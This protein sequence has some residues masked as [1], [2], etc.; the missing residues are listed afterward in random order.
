[1]VYADE[2]RSLEPN[3]LLRLPDNVFELEGAWNAKI[4]IVPTKLHPFSSKKANVALPS[5]VSKNAVNANALD[6]KNKS[7]PHVATA[8]RM[9]TWR[10]EVRKRVGKVANSIANQSQQLGSGTLPWQLVNKH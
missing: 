8:L 4:S 6:D 10:E 9:V 2:V 5:V 3:V 7:I 1:M